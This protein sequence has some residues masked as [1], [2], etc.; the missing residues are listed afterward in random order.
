M[1][2]NSVCFGHSLFDRSTSRFLKRYLLKNAA[3]KFVKLTLSMAF[4]SCQLS[5][6]SRKDDR[7]TR[8]DIKFSAQERSS[9][10]T[11]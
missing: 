1:S 2:A 8:I 4:A 5:L 9:H 11:N 10:E 6:I 3:E 7:C